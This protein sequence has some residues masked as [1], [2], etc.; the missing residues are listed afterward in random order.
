MTVTAAEAGEAMSAVATKLLEAQIVAPEGFSVLSRVASDVARRKTELTWSIEVDRGQPISFEKVR[1]RSGIVVSP[2]LM[3]KGITVAQGDRHTPPFDQLD[4]ALEI[5]DE[6]NQPVARWHLDLA[7]QGSDEEFQSGPLIHLQYGGHHHDDRSMDAPLKAPRWCHPPM[8]LALVCEV[9]AAN[10]YE[11][12][13]AAKLRE[14]P[15]WCRA[16]GTFQRL[17][18]SVYVEK[19][20]NCLSVS[21]S[22][23]LN[24]MWA[25]AW[26]QPAS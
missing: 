19:L 24:V 5:S 22:T 15:G 3:A 18:Y 1:D 16:I 10:F 8:E 14:D 11:E 2:M 20:R 23:A 7:N 17:C 21:S 4:M 9:V 6:Q 25:N 12:L 26:G 13:W